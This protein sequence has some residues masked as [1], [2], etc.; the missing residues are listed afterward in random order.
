MVSSSFADFEEHFD[1]LAGSQPGA[2]NEIRFVGFLKAV[3]NLNHALHDFNF[4]AESALHAEL[5]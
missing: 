4:I 5:L 2:R 3:E 1:A